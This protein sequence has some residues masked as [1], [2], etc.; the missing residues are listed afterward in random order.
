MFA[1]TLYSSFSTD[2]LKESHTFYTEVLGLETELIGDRFLHIFPTEGHPIVI[3]W[4][5]EHKPATYTALNFQVQDIRQKVEDLKSK[6]VSFLRYE[7]PFETDSDHISLD[8][9]GSHIAWFKD[10]GGNILALIEN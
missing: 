4:K 7:E 1:S 9:N 5:K 6:G 10:T 8:E 3:Y 2:Q